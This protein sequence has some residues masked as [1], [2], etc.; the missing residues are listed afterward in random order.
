MRI[1]HRN[2]R[3][4]H[5]QPDFFKPDI[6][7]KSSYFSNLGL[8]PESSDFVVKA[9]FFRLELETT[10]FQLGVLGETMKNHPTEVVVPLLPKNKASHAGCVASL[11]SCHCQRT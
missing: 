1:L 6:E 8:T 2:H 9:L 11:A 4:C 10:S 3:K 7:P 5:C